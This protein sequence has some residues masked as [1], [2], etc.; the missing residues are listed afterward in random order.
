MDMA[1]STT[2]VASVCITRHA[3]N[4]LGTVTG[5]VNRVIQVPFATK[6]RLMCCTL[7]D[8]SH[9]GVCMIKFHYTVYM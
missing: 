2:A 5:D 7:I 4:R 1:A 6:V 3:T 8:K 9:R